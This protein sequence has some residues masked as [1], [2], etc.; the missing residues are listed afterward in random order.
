MNFQSLF[1]QEWI[2]M[3]SLRSMIFAIISVLAIV[4]ISFLTF[5]VL[6]IPPEGITMTSDQMDIMNPFGQMMSLFSGIFAI[7]TSLFFILQ[8]GDEY[9]YGLIRKNVIDG[10]DRRDIFNGKMLFLFLSYLAWTLIILVVF[11]ICGAIKLGGDVGMLIGSI[12]PEQLLKYYLHVIFFG[13][14]VFFLVSITRSGTISLIIFF[15]MYVAELLAKPALA[16]FEMKNVAN[17][18][19]LEVATTV[20]AADYISTELLITYLIYLFLLILGGQLSIYKRDL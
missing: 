19:P 5:G 20:R 11:V 12:Q 8:Y 3:T 2:K 10:M 13:A 7:I 6:G 14:F 15:G 1:K 4:G 18:L 16:Y 17:Y 9:K